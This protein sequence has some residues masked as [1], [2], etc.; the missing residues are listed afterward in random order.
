MAE[1]LVGA[2]G[3]GY[4]AGGLPAYA[5][6]FSFVEVNVTFYR[7]VPEARARRWRA[8]VPPAFTFAVKGSRAAPH[9]GG[10]RGRGPRGPRGVGPPRGSVGPRGPFLRRPRPARGPPEGHG[11]RR[12]PG[13]R[14]PLPPAASGR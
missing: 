4:C 3:W 8:Q 2:G 11:G 5:K 9:E 12:D 1:A 6:A 14:R 7:P 10:L 13:R